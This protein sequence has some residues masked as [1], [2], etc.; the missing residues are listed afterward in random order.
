MSL[1]NTY[2]ENADQYLAMVK[3]RSETVFESD[4]LAVAFFDVIGD[5]AGQRVLDAGC[6]EGFVARVL[7]SHGA[8][9]TAMDISRPLVDVA[10]SK[11]SEATIDYRVHDLSSPLPELEGQ[12]DLVA[13]HLVL[14]DVPD[15][16][17]FISTIASLMSPTAKAVF[18]L[19]NPYSAVLR[20][21]ASSYFAS[22]EAVIYQGMA[23]SGVEVYY[24]H[25]TLEDYV[26]ALR[27][28]GL[29][30]RSLKDVPPSTDMLPRR[31]KWNT[32]PFLMVL[33]CVKARHEA[34]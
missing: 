7:N 3:D 9:V 34:Q 2:D 25:R 33:E 28:S 17:G 20:E 12:F 19:N 4:P 21:K 31:D 23:Q 29:L 30:L 24:Y 22:G 11:D 13:S 15:Y 1:R 6:G 32:V 8:C 18:S 14:N 26:T 27:D 10:R 16:L 5:V